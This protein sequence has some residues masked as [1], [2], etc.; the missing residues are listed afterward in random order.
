MAPVWR[1]DNDLT[2]VLS[3]RFRREFLKHQ[4]LH[5]QAPTERERWSFSGD[6]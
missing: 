3:F 5:F 4:N 6:I 1:T 2:V